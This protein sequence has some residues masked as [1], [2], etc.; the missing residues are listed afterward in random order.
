MKISQFEEIRI[1]RPHGVS[2]KDFPEG[3]LFNWRDATAQE[4]VSFRC[5]CGCKGILNLPVNGKRGCQ[6]ILTKNSDLSVSLSP[7]IKYGGCGAHFYIEN[8]KIRWA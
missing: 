4:Y 3:I 2:L 1:G 5:P 6:W 8:N 7:S